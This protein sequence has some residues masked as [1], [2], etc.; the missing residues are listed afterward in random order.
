MSSVKDTPRSN[1]DKQVPWLGRQIGYVGKYE[2]KQKQWSDGL[3]PTEKEDYGRLLQEYLMRLPSIERKNDFPIWSSRNTVNLKDMEKG[4]WYIMYLSKKD[5]MPEKNV[6][7]RTPSGLYY[8]TET[9]DY[10]GL[11][12]GVYIKVWKDSQGDWF[13]NNAFVHAEDTEGV[14]APLIP[15]ASFINWGKINPLGVNK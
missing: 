12:R 7:Y 10:S 14:F 15:H 9:S 5:G 8:V 1:Q 6:K 11:P 4:E 3:Y 2:W 13:I